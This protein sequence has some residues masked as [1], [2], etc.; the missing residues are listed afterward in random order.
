MRSL[1]FPLG[2]LGHVRSLG[3]ILPLGALGLAVAASTPG[4]TAAPT[5]AST[6]AVQAGTIHLVQDGKV[7]EGGAT[8]LITDGKIT[9]VG[10]DIDIP[11][12]ARI[13]DYGP[14]AVIAPGL[15]A[16]NSTFGG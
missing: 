5:A 9:A 1:Q 6:V 3:L 2:P 13:V 11:A 15:V 10:K 7:L 16:A 8:I 14:D 4:R 12:G